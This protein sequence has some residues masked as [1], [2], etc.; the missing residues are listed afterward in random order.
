MG[1]VKVRSYREEV[2]NRLFY[3]VKTI[4]IFTIDFM[5]WVNRGPNT[6]PLFYLTIGGG[7]NIGLKDVLISAGV[8]GEEP[9]GVYALLKF[10]EEDISDFLSDYRFLLFPCINPFGF[11]RGYRFNSQPD[12]DHEGRSMDIN[13]HFKSNTDCREANR[14]M[15]ILGRKKMKFLFT[16]DLHE[17]DPNWADEEFSTSDSPHTFYMWENAPDMNIRVGDKVIKKVSKM[18]PVCEWPS[19]YKDINNGGVIWYPEGCG[20][21]IYAQGTT[22]EAFLG[23][24]Y[25]PQAF[26]LE[27][28]C[29]WPMDQRVLA[30]RVALRSI[31]EL[32]RDAGKIV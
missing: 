3:L 19:I 31:L 16:V 7:Q 9:A 25:T 26:T 1:L 5:G 4:K 29:G 30:H 17:T 14:I 24:N 22:L 10:L 28:P 15:E 11:E 32:K 27:T 2:L 13:R 18:F 21:P 20:N 6:Y 23:K 12:P 8:H